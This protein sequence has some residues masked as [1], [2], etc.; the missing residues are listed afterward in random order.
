MRLSIYILASIALILSIYFSYTFNIIEMKDISVSALAL[1]G[2][3]FGAT[4]AFRLTERKEY[5]Q[6]HQN[7]RECLNKAI[8]ILIRQLNA[9]HQLKLEIDLYSGIYKKAFNMQAVVP[10]PYQDLYHDFEGLSFI[11]ES[12]NPGL[13]FELTTEQERFHQTMSSLSFRNDFFIKEVMPAVAIADLNGKTLSPEQVQ[14]IL[15]DRIYYGAIQGIEGAEKMLT[16]SNES[17]PLMLKAII[18]FAKQEYP[19]YKFLKYEI[20]A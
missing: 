10:P 6:L 12:E 1:I 7:R 11:L 16:L 8:F 17:L 5:L 3:F 13:I 4:F 15:G 19:K 9:V 14:G 20:P 18:E 2:T